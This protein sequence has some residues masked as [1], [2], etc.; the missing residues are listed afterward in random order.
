MILRE[1]Q[2]SCKNIIPQLNFYSIL[3]DGAVIMRQFALLLQI[4]H[5][6]TERMSLV[7]IVSKNRLIKVRHSYLLAIICQKL[8][9]SRKCIHTEQKKKFIAVNNQLHLYI[10]SLVENYINLLKNPNIP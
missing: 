7:H 5:A 6:T 9:R 4:L 2:N 10:I 1:L 8:T 3:P